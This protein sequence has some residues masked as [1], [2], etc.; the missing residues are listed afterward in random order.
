[1][2]YQEKVGTRA[3]VKAL[4]E[5][6][7]ANPAIEKY[8]GY[9]ETK[10]YG[11]NPLCNDYIKREGEVWFDNPGFVSPATEQEREQAVE[12]VS[13]PAC[14]E[15]IFKEIDEEEIEEEADEAEA[16]ADAEAEIE[17]LESE[18]SRLRAERDEA[19]EAL[20]ALRD[21]LSLVAKLANA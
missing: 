21:A 16:L 12:A 5:R 18:I 13:A 3:E 20:V 9:T 10:S 17:F 14:E 8:R 19:V 11:W 6:V 15:D 1:M 4:Y 7:V 2:N